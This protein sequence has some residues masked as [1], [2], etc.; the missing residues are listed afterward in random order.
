VVVPRD[1]E[2]RWNN[3]D[4]TANGKWASPGDTALTNNGRK[5]AVMPF[6]I[7]N[8]TDT[9]SFRVFVNGAVPDSIWK[10][11]REI[12][13][14]NA[15][16]AIQTH[17]SLT[18]FPATPNPTVLPR[19]GDVYRIRTYKPFAPGDEF[20]FTTTAARY[21]ASKAKQ[22][23]GGIYVVP[24]PYV[25]YSSM[26]GPGTDATKRGDQKIQFRNL[27]PQCTIRIY[28]M[29][30]EL[31]TT[32]EKNDGSSMVDWNLLSNEGQRLAYGVYIYHV[33]APGVGEKIGRFALIK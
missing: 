19:Q 33:D 31:V 1:F 11:G 21:D 26:E 24:N 25:A 6:R 17:V 16:G 8:V 5:I 12:I 20:T 27:P 10:P 13:I 3:T 14:L 7:V 4:T 15:S 30:G 29:V 32:L 23:L 2:L 28:T 22:M 18:L 9:T